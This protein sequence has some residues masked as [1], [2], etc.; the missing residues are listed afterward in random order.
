[1]FGLTTQDMPMPGGMVYKLL[2]ADGEQMGGAMPQMHEGAPSMW[3]TWVAVENADAAFALVEANGGR[4]LSPP[5]DMPGVGRMAVSQG[6][7]GSVVGL[8]QPEG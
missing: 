4:M 2:F 7:D 1:V 3:L 6:P 8:I 5:M